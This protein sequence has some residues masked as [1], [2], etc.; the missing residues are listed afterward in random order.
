MISSLILMKDKDTFSCFIKPSKY[1][2]PVI[3]IINIINLYI[4][5]R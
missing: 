2:K 5:I 3:I 4:Q 1:I